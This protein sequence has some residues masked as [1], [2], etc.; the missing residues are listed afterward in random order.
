MCLT[1][2]P[3]QHLKKKK[4]KKN[5]Y[6]TTVSLLSLSFSKR[7]MSISST[8]MILSLLVTISLGVLILYAVCQL[9]KRCIESR[10]E[11]KNKK[12]NLPTYSH[13]NDND[14]CADV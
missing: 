1:L 3:T 12:Q 10:E 2:T 14:D 8:A 13:E 4:K 6:S 11:K 5:Y 7:K 9:V